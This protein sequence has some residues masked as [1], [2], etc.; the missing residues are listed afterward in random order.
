[1]SAVQAALGLAQMERID[2]LIEHKRQI[3]N[4]YQEFLGSFNK[5]ALNVEPAGVKNSYWMVTIIPDASVG[6]EK[7]EFQDE[8]RKRNIDSRPFFSRQSTLPAYNDE[9]SIRDRLPE[10]PNGSHP[11]TYGINLPSGYDLNKEKVKR[12]CGAVIAVLE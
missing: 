9:N 2:S 4:W 12:I 8:L 3:F 1:M 11:A 7:F 10:N 5:L 6:I